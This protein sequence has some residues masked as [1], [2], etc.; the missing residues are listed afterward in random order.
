MGALQRLAI[1]PAASPTSLR[2]G[3]G[4]LPAGS[5]RLRCRP[6]APSAAARRECVAVYGDRVSDQSDTI[7]PGIPQPA[8]PRAQ[9]NGGAAR[10]RAGDRAGR[11]P[12]HCDAHPRGD[13]GGE[14][15]CCGRQR[16]RAGRRR[17]RERPDSPRV[18]PLVRRRHRKRARSRGPL[19][20]RSPA[21]PGRNDSPAPPPC[22]FLPVPPREGHHDSRRV[23]PQ[24]DG[25]AS[26]SPARMRA[27]PPRCRGSARR[28]EP[29]DAACRV[30]VA[31]ISHEVGAA[32][33]A[34]GTIVAARRQRRRGNGRRGL[35]VVP[36]VGEAA[37][38]LPWGRLEARASAEP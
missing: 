31:A 29:D 7:W 19:L 3:A 1:Y 37:G 26:E 28:V 10:E 5:E 21:R 4:G 9:R 35:V 33:R 27:H 8:T 38:W 25:A 22:D 15:V 6:L 36:E 16:G 30:R 11:Q 13:A 32:A 12:P 24:R 14:P 23:E 18:G 34:A 17:H 20:C 2:P